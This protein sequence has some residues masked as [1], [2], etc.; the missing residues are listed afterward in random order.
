MGGLKA[1]EQLSSPGSRGLQPNSFP[2][3]QPACFSTRLCPASYR[4]Q[5]ALF[6]LHVPTGSYLKRPLRLPWAPTQPGPPG[7]QPS[8][9]SATSNHSLQPA[10]CYFCPHVYRAGGRTRETDAFQTPAS[11]PVVRTGADGRLGVDQGLQLVPP[12]CN[13]T[14]DKGR[15]TGRRLFILA[16]RASSSAPGWRAC[17]ESGWRLMELSGGWMSGDRVL[18]QQGLD[19]SQAQGSNPALL[20]VR[21][22]TCRVSEGAHVEG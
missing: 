2:T 11:V 16:G 14:G 3:A 12:A 8:P 1:L 15:V 6:L 4:L 5:S 22:Q 10:G 18:W 9:D 13:G 19:K 7:Q 21:G 20:L 17:F